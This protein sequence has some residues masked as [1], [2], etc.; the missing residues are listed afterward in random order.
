MIRMAIAVLS[1]T[2]IAFGLVL[3][4]QAEDQM[5]SLTGSPKSLTIEWRFDQPPEVVWR[6]WTD[7]DWMARWAG[8]DPKGKVLS[9]ELDVRP[10]GRFEV[11][12]ANGD[13]TQHTFHGVYREVKLPR[14]L[15]FTW[16]WRS[17]PGVETFI[18]VS[19]VPEGQGTLMRFEHS[20]LGYASSHDYASG[21][22]S[23]FQKMESVVASRL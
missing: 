1:S 18:I 13:G 11:T 19:L 23:T 4:V 9:V 16:G 15:A 5:E 6:A 14:R 21:W 12:F 20:G 8:S 10:Q 2:S 22:R 3:S 17:E 7:P